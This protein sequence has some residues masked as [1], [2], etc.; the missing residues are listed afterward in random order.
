MSRPRSLRVSKH[1]SEKEMARIQNRE[2]NH[3]AAAILKKGLLDLGIG[4]E[5][6][7]V[8]VGVDDEMFEEELEA[9]IDQFARGFNGSGTESPSKRTRPSLFEIESDNDDDDFDEVE[10]GSSRIPF[11]GSTSEEACASMDRVGSSASLTEED[12]H[13]MDKEADEA[14]KRGDFV[15]ESEDWLDDRT[16]SEVVRPR[17]EG[18]L[19][20]FS[21]PWKAGN[22]R[23]RATAGGGA[24][25]RAEQPG[26]GAPVVHSSGNV[27]G[28]QSGGGAPVVG[29]SKAPVKKGAKVRIASKQSYW[30]MPTFTLLRKQHLMIF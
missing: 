23:G 2:S 1:F 21:D 10:I 13:V 15:N 27:D 29:S 9:L 8:E 6:L 11:I 20:E 22:R 7:S 5:S 16:Y 19:E 25:A 30:L 24:S 17:Q 4:E 28:L 3:E 26:G 14:R 18:G 12:Y